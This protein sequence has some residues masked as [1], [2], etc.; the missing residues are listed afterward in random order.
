MI[1][2][3]RIS[4]W[5]SHEIVISLFVCLGFPGVFLS[6][7]QKPLYQL[8]GNRI[9]PYVYAAYI[10]DYARTLERFGSTYYSA[11]I[12]Y[13]FPERALVNLLGLEA[14]YYTYRFLGLSIATAAVYAISRR[15]YSLAAAVFVAAWLCFTPWLPRSL[16]WTHYEGFAVVYMLAAAAFLLVPAKWEFAGHAAAGV[17]LAF[18][19]NCNFLV[20]AVA[21][22]FL[23]SWLI[24]HRGYDMSR[25]LSLALCVLGGFILCYAALI[26]GL[27]LEQPDSGF[28]GMAATFSAAF[29]LL[30]GGTDEWVPLG[31]LLLNPLN[32]NTV[33]LLI[34]ITLFAYGSFV[35]LKQRSVDV[36]SERARFA[37][38]AL[39][40]LGFVGALA[41]SLHVF[42]KHLWLS[43]YYYNIYFFPAS[44]LLLI[45][46][47]GHI[48][49]RY[50]STDTLYSATTFFILFWI[51]FSFGSSVVT[52]FGAA[53]WAGI[54]ALVTAVV[55]VSLLYI[56]RGQSAAALIAG[57]LITSYL[58]IFARE[59]RLTANATERQHE[60]DVYHGAVFLQ[61]FI[62]S[63][64]P[65]TR[66]IGFW[67][68]NFDLLMYSVQSMFLWD[69][70]R[71]A[72]AD[73]DH[74][75]MPVLDERTRAAMVKNDFLASL[76]TSEMETDVALN[77]I[78]TAGLPFRV[79]SRGNFSGKTWGFHVTLLKAFPRPLGIQLFE[80]SLFRLVPVEGARI[81]QVANGIQVVTGDQQWAY[82]L[83]GPLRGERDPS[84]AER[85]I[86]R[87]E[88]EV[89]EGAVGIAIEDANDRSKLF[90]V[91]VGQ[92]NEMET[93][94][95]EIPSLASAGQFIVRNYRASPSTATVHSIRVF[96]A[97]S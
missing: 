76:G 65:T 31:K 16:L 22:V 57:I 10:N 63:Q 69:Y 9:D 61:K 21:G 88:I 20:V 5:L 41:L 4:R 94:D 3:D 30:A 77:A 29:V 37:L 60:W 39:L 7:L 49:T 19:V 11:R 96:R 87:V 12:A 53:M 17:A 54:F 38:A 36:A 90:E 40:Y 79:V 83:V 73:Q 85:V 75:G 8:G 52:S 80:V 82:S 91:S 64:V 18:A 50:G 68:R 78:I 81:T 74:P 23:P 56:N 84:A 48:D 70:T 62:N 15:Y 89:Q 97:S 67:Y 58:P 43:A 71:V 1:L 28:A 13:I 66:T 6:T 24:L 32:H 95:L 34:P 45:S 93:V 86:V 14:G 26:L 33:I 25:M 47:A 72:P 92:S 35:L 55:F 2:K 42:W 46:L 59:F 44:A 51:L 27:D